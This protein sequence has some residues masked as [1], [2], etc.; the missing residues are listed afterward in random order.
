[1]ED[2]KITTGFNELPFDTQSALAEVSALLN[3]AICAQ[4]HP[5]WF[6]SPKNVVGKETM[7][8]YRIVSKMLCDKEI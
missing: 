1:M 3:V 4:K 6:T 2:I 8:A 7:N 5:Q